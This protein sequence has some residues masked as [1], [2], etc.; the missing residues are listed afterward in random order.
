MQEKLKSLWNSKWFLD[1]GCSRH[2]IEDPQNFLEFKSND[3][4]FVTFGDNTK[5][6]IINVSKVGNTY[7]SVIENVLLA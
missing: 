6:K 5:D 2:M 3:A 4:S 1:S 7:S